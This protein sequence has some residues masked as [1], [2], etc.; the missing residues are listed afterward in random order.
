MTTSLVITKELLADHWLITITLS[1]DSSLPKNIFVYENNG[2]AELGSFFGICNVDEMTRLKAFE[3]TVIPVFGNR[4]VKFDRAKIKVDLTDDV[5]RVINRII[6]S[7]TE[8]DIAYQT[9]RSVTKIVKI[10]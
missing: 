5:D 9:Q 6:K 7:V 1:E 3:G 4:Y 2:N 8:L 10:S